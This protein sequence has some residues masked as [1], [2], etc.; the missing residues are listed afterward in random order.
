VTVTAYVVD[1]MD[2]SKVA[3]AAR[4]DGIDVTFV[5]SGAALGEAVK[6][7]GPEIVLVDL[8]RADAVDAIAAV[9][10]QAR[11]V[12]FGAHVDTDRLAAA[13][14]AGAASV[15]ARGTFFADPARWMRG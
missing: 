14:R 7:A 12:A 6:T 8:G 13:E 2:R 10:G 15:L 4:A 11:V 1:L 5:R 3:A 9:A